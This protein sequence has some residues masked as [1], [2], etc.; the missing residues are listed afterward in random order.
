MDW[1]IRYTAHLN[2]ADREVLSYAQIG[3]VIDEAMDDLPMIN[4]Q[5]IR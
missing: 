4:H 3:G 5:G 1:G 2:D